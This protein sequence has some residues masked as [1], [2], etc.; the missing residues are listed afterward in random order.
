MIWVLFSMLTLSV[1]LAMI[2]S[3]RRGAFVAE[4]KANAM[5][6]YEDQLIELGRDAERGVISDS[7]KH[8]A[9]TEIKR[10]M[11]KMSEDGSATVVSKPSALLIAAALVPVGAVGIYSELGRPE[12][13]TPEVQ[14]Q[15]E[16]AQELRR[17]T[18]QLQRSLR[19]DP[20]GGEIEGWRL[21]AETFGNQSWYEEALAAHRVIT[22]R[23]EAS[24]IDFSLA[25][26]ALISANGGQVTAEAKAWLAKSLQLAPGNPAAV[27]YLALGLAQEGREVEALELLARRVEVENS[28][29]EWMP[30]FEALGQQLAAATGERMFALPNQSGPSAEEIEAA[31]DMTAEEREEMIEGMVSGLASRLEETPEDLDGWL[32]LARAYS[33]LGQIDDAKAALEEVL[34]RADPS[35]PRHVAAKNAM[36]SLE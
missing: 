16:N 22:S 20:D 15:L 2:W 1:V 27:Y 17:L 24:S 34:Q 21:L 5:S 32:Q 14:S 13:A 31:S 4:R 9:E 18:T 12:F 7:E 11:L 35:D 25:A 26:E 19:G 6:I 23:N 28:L 8:A 29:T 36:L 30:S 10:R 3:S 33:V